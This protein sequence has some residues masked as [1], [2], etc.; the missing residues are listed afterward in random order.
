MD[1]D[2]AQSVAMTA[3]RCS[4]EIGGL[5]SLVKQHCTDEEYE[6]IS[7]AIGS[8]V[9]ELREGLMGAVFKLVP[10]LEAEFENRLSKY[11]RSFY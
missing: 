1:K 2:I 4:S 10:E 5:A 9:Y 3:A 6:L 11:G 7:V 8:A